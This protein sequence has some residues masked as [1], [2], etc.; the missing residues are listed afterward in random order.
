[1]GIFLSKGTNEPF[2]VIYEFLYKYVPGFFLFRDPTKWYVIIALSYSILVP[3][4]L[5][6]LKRINRKLVAVVFLFVWVG[7]LRLTLVGKVDGNLTPPTIT[8]DYLLLKK[9][10]TEDSVQ[11]RTLWFPTIE[12]YGYIDETHPGLS[13]TSVFSETSASGI[14][15][16]LNN[17]T[18]EDQLKTEG[19]SYLIVPEDVE[20]NIFLDDYT[21]SESLR[22]S[23]VSA[24]DSLSYLHK[25]TSFKNVEVYKLNKPTGFFMI[26][27]DFVSGHNLNNDT[28]KLFIPKHNVA[29][30]LHVAMN[31][32]PN[33]RL[34]IDEKLI[35]PNQTA[36]GF[37]SFDI[38]SEKDEDAILYYLP[39]RAAMFGAIFSEAFLLGCLLLYFRIVRL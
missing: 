15:R 14:L 9:I 5:E 23:Y 36:E 29:T 27:N 7:L 31:Y 4:T 8:T 30:T 18:V 13:A 16:A 24:L 25:N 6:A 35:S 38:F 17:P 37:M 12:K 11:G 26:G 21:Y 34:K 22:N 28:W 1:M 3:K 19:I 39:T 2:G 33:W 20:R 32:D 10:L